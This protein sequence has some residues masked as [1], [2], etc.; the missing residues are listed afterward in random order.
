MSNNSSSKPKN[1][2]RRAQVKIL[3]IMI[4]YILYGVLTV[5]SYTTTITSVDT[6]SES[7]EDYFSCQGVG[8]HIDRDCGPPPK[9]AQLVLIVLSI[10]LVRL[11]PVVI[12]VFTANCTCNCF[13]SRSRKSD[14]LDNNS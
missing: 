3:F 12:L 10:L 6:A 7:L 1:Q 5:T 11:M 13:K 9:N 14:T 4:Y 8:V 2:I